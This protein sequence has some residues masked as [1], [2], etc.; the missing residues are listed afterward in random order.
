MA[1]YPSSIRR[2]R[3]SAKAYERNKV[4]RSLMKTAIKRVLTA[5]DKETAAQR[6]P[7][8]ISILDKLVSKGIIHRNKAANQKSRLTRHVNQ[9]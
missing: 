3:K 5:E 9:L 6:L 4:Y 2:I 8:S 1:N 7:K